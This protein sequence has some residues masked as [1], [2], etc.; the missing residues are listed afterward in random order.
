MHVYMYA[1]PVREEL[2]HTVH[3]FTILRLHSITTSF[4][5]LCYVYFHPHQIEF[6]RE[7]Y[8]CLFNLRLAYVC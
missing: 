3:G 1:A 4:N 2:L 7:N 6:Y 5:P 8:S